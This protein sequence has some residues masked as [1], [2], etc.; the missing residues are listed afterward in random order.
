[1]HQQ[2]H[3]KLLVNQKVNYDTTGNEICTHSA[4]YDLKKNGW[5]LR[6]EINSITLQRISL[7]Y[8]FNNSRKNLQCL[9]S[10]KCFSQY[11]KLKAKAV[12]L[13]TMKVLEGRYSSYSFSTSTLDRGEW[14]VSRPGRTLSPRRGPPVPTVQEAGW[15][16]QLV[17]T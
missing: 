9:L 5:S 10:F 16:P 8:S 12:P 11:E 3:K 6:T 14:S 15:A 2:R 1:M 4:L 7:P 13:H 17:W